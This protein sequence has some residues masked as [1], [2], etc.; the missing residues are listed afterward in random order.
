MSKE[1]V[2]EMTG[3]VIDVLP[4][5]MFKIVVDDTAHTY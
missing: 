1:D 5:N 3:K 2:I 4:G